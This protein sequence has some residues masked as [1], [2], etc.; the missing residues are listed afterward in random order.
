MDPIRFDPRNHVPEV[1]P[2]DFWDDAHGFDAVS[3]VPVAMLPR[4]KPRPAAPEAPVA[5]DHGAGLRIQ[6]KDLPRLVDDELY[7]L[8]VREIDGRVLRLAPAVPTV[9]RAVRQL[10]CQEVPV[11]NSLTPLPRDVSNDWGRTGRLP[12][13]W[14]LGTSLGVAAVVIGAMM[15]LPLINQSNA[16]HPWPGDDGLVVEPVED[17]TGM[18]PVQAMLARQAE[19]T[20][21]FKTVLS[22]TT[23]AEV[24]PWVCEATAVEPLIRAHHRSLAVPKGWP[25]L[26]TILWSVLDNNGHPYGLMEGNLPDF[27]KF[28]AYWVIAGNRLRLDWKATTG[29]GTAT[30]EELAHQRGTPAEIR[31]KILPGRYFTAVYPE[32]EFQCYQ[33]SAPDDSQAIWCYVRRDDPVDVVLGELCL[34]GEILDHASTQQKITVRLKQGLVGSKPNQ[35]LLAA[36][37]HKEWISP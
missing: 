26:S 37:L 21:I 33:L 35:W 30:F 20:R 8:E 7:Q 36:V 27:S 23:V 14:L 3:G 9:P 6:A 1:A 18:E 16:A 24:L 5:S 10:V 2:G 11:G 32:A 15:V 25:D 4:K 19:A 17:L 28:T 13:R 29:Y 12:V 22:A 31:G 34:D